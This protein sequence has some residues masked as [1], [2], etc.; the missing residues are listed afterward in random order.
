[1]VLSHGGGV[2]RGVQITALE[3]CPGLLR[4]PRVVVTKCD[5]AHRESWRGLKVWTK[6]E[7]FIEEEVRPR[8]LAASLARP[9]HCDAPN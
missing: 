8:G 3:A 6:F 9:L 4:D 2:G 5:A 1:M 7:N